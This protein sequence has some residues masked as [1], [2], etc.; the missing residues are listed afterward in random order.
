MKYLILTCLLLGAYL[1]AAQSD[2][3]MPISPENAANVTEL[4]AFSGHID[5]AWSV[6]FSPDGQLLASSG[7]DHTIRLWDVVSGNERFT[8]TAESAWTIGLAF[9]PDGRLLAS[10]ADE[11]TVR[12]WDIP[13]RSESMF[14]F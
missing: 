2:S 11:N 5:G 3:L 10:A 12:L 1:P 6:A 14:P 8:L 7:R 4:A 9:S 13:T